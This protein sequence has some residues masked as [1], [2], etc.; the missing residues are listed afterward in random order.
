MQLCNYAI[1]QVK[2][3]SGAVSLPFIF[4]LYYHAPR[5]SNPAPVFNFI[6]KRRRLLLP[7]K[8]GKIYVLL[9]FINGIIKWFQILKKV[10]MYLKR[11]IDSVLLTW[12]K[13]ENRKPLLLRG[14][15]QVD[16]SSA[17]WCRPDPFTLS[18][19]IFIWRVPFS[20]QWKPPFKG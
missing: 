8:N 6:L 14:A 20:M 17:I 12:S 13:D 9:P 18:I 10:K 5:A 19:S 11:E 3:Q 1:L 4:Y 16:K 15:R 2:S 7:L